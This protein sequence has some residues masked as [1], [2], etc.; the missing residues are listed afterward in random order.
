M[1]SERAAD[2]PRETEFDNPLRKLK[3]QYK[4][5]DIQKLKRIVVHFEKAGKQLE[6]F[7]DRFV[8]DWIDELDC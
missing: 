6:Q 4:A 3:K 2:P 7:D 8:H 5:K 1:R